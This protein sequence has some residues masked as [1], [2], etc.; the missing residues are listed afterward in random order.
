MKWDVLVSSLPG[1]HVLQ[2]AHWAKVKAMNGWHPMYLRWVD[3]FGNVIAAVCVH[4]KLVPVLGRLGGMCLLY[5][6]RGPI[7][8]WEDGDL[9]RQ[10]L[11]DLQQFAIK[12]HAIFLKIDPQVILGKGIPDSETAVSE[13]TGEM[14]TN[15]LNKNGWRYS[16]EQLQ[17]KNTVILDVSPSEE[18]ILDRLKQKTRYNIRLAKRK[19]ITIEQAADE[20]LHTLYQMY[21]ETASRDGFIIRTRDYYL[22]VWRNLIKVRIAY[23]LVAKY[24]SQILSGLVLFV[25]GKTAYY[26]YGMSTDRMREAMPNHLLQWE[27]IRLAKS[28]GCENYDF[29]GAPDHFN[30]D[31][32]MYGVYR[33]KEGFNG[34]IIRGIGAWDFSVLPGMYHL[35][36]RLLPKILNIMRSIGR[37]RIS[38]E[39]K[40]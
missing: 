20:D 25:F 15:V 24:E 1:T 32:Q 22:S 39:A 31:D 8:D 11:N 23:P 21:A 2:S 9:C 13:P 19:G 10:V 33:F 30:A 37:I 27:A 12:N 18:N 40:R 3:E 36:T 28:L 34:T 5:A 14:V 7:L 29:W 6:P 16:N 26:F 17:F 35:Y 38:R 4:R